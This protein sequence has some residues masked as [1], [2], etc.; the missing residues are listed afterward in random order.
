MERVF[1]IYIR[2][3][4]ERLWEEITDS[5]IRSKYQFGNRISSDWSPGSRFEMTHP[6]A[7]GLFGEGERRT[8]RCTFLAPRGL[9]TPTSRTLSD[10]AHPPASEPSECVMAPRCCH[11]GGCDGRRRHSGGH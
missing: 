6:G 9:L 10:R 8:S 4:P 11:P 2:T 1:E 7:P 5:E 3:A